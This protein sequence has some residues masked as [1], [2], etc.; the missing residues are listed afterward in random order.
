VSKRSD[1]DTGDAGDGR[2]D[3]PM[4]VMMEI[5]MA[6]TPIATETAGATIFE[7]MERN[8]NGKWCRRSEAPVTS[9]ARS[10]WRSD[11]QR[12]IR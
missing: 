7:P 3:A 9:L 5:A 1:L 6:V 12:T 8:E 10:D 2:S 4:D 11:M